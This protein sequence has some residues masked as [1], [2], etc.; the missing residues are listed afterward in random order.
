LDTSQK[1]D[2][3]Q[4]HRP[5]LSTDEWVKAKLLENSW[6]KTAKKKNP[7]EIVF[8]EREKGKELG[9]AATVNEA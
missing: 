9:N 2:G 4:C 5:S 6:T 7:M 8:P 1:R 3:K